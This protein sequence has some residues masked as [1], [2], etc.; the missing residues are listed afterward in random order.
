MNA[1][2]CVRACRVRRAVTVSPVTRWAERDMSTV[3]RSRPGRAA[4]VNT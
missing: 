3:C 4:A 1:A 2:G